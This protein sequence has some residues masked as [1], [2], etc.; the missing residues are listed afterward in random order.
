MTLASLES[1]RGITNARLLCRNS[2]KGRA[3]CDSSCP[4]QLLSLAGDENEKAVVT[5]EDVQPPSSA[6]LQ[7]SQGFQL[8]SATELRYYGWHLRNNPRT[9]WPR[10]LS[11]ANPAQRAFSKAKRE[12]RCI[13]ALLKVVKAASDALYSTVSVAPEIKNVYAGYV[14]R[15]H[16][17]LKTRASC[18]TPP[19]KR[20]RTS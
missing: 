17:S 18:D 13:R 16:R 3:L 7:F 5:A 19:V 6:L 1:Q 8:C 15:S 2:K 9:R 4:A 11:N 14:M 12:V 10:S 20:Q